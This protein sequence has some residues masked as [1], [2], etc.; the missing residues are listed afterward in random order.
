MIHEALFT[1]LRSSAGVAALVSE[2]SS[3]VRY[4]IYPLVMPQHADGDL[5]MVPCVVYTQV[6]ANRSVRYAGTDNVVEATFQIDAY[7]KTYTGSIQL[8]AAVRTAMLD[9]SGTLNG[10]EIKTANL[11]NEF[12]L[13]DPEPG[14]YRISQ[15]WVIWYVE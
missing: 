12:A 6:G 7:A 9:Y 2:N 8:A 14:L 5:S 4:R 10:T 1:L 15:S 11:T 3:P 13:E